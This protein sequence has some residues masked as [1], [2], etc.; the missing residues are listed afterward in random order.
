MG[1]E[2]KKLVYFVLFGLVA[3]TVPATARPMVFAHYMPGLTGRVNYLQRMNEAESGQAKGAG[4]APLYAQQFFSGPAPWGSG[5]EDYA[6]YEIQTAINAGVD[7]FVFDYGGGYGGRQ[8]FGK[9]NIPQV[10]LPVIDAFFAVAEK[11]F[12]SFR[13]TLALDQSGTDKSVERRRITIE[14]FMQ[15]HGNSPVL[16]EKDGRPVFFSY[17][18][19]ALA[20][21]QCPAPP[22]RRSAG[23]L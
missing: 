20:P 6:R 8:N 19:N 18:A 23:V 2:M 14:Q 1:V 11:D 4:D 9:L 7:G 12:K 22:H 15:R 10:S 21:Y 16:F 13:L 17:R 3:C 5:I